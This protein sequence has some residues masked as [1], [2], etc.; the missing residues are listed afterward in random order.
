MKENEFVLVI[1]EGDLDYQF[2]GEYL[3]E[4]TDKAK[5]N[6]KVTNGDILTKDVSGQ[7]D[8]LIRQIFTSVLD[9]TKLQETDFVKIIQICDIDGSFFTDDMFIVDDGRS[10]YDKKTYEYSPYNNRVYVKST[11]DKQ[12]LL[13]TWG[14]K[15]GNQIDLKSTSEIRVSENRS[16]PFEIY[17]ISLF[18]EHLLK[19]DV[20]IES[21]EKRD[22]I[23][24]YLDYNDVSNFIDLI[25]TKKL[26][27]D[28]LSSWE[29][30]AT[31]TDKYS[32]CTNLTFLIESMLEMS[33]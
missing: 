23:E 4:I 25:N 2:Y 30:L 29:L 28:Y 1:V 3:S 13:R 26:G 9:K 10:Y 20:L 11:E 31:R 5:L 17:Y 6:I 7:P 27:H 33:I 16:I 19:D 24:T 15:K 14:V 32:A 12:R 22:F 18:L 21:D 8:K